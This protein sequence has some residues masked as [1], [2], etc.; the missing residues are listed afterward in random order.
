[1][2]LLDYLKSHKLNIPKDNY[3]KESIDNYLTPEESVIYDYMI[4]IVDDF[5]YNLN[6]FYYYLMMYI[7]GQEEEE[8]N[9]IKRIS[10]FI[11]SMNIYYS[12]AYD[13]IVYYYNSKS[14][15]LEYFD[16][17]KI[18]DDEFESIYQSC[19]CN[20]ELLKYKNLFLKKNFV[21]TLELLKKDAK[22]SISKQYF[23]G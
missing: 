8:N 16:I 22:T 15:L 21:Y 13:F 12:Y 20:I 2:E 10:E 7:I 17:N 11:T 9:N 18:L 23:G 3:E 14:S 19:D 4:T 5:R 1:M 6:M